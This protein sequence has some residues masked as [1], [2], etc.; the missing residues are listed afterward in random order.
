MEEQK[1]NKK[2]PDPL[3]KAGGMKIKLKPGRAA[4]GVTPDENGMA[5]VDA[6]TAEYLVRIG[7]A[8]YIKETTDVN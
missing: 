1:Q 7:Y 8:D 3:N 4:E 5:T 6:T 2:M